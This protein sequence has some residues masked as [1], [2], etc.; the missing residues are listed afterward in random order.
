MKKI[1]LY[2]LR[3]I[4][5]KN[6]KQKKGEKE[7]NLII[8]LVAT[9]VLRPAVSIAQHHN[10]RSTRYIIRFYCSGLLLALLSCLTAIT[11]STHQRILGIV[12]YRLHD[13]ETSSAALSE[14]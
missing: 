4:K 2:R 11:W 14:K 6:S 9:G 12:P 7:P 13:A 1:Q 3:G 8:N 10:L 5:E